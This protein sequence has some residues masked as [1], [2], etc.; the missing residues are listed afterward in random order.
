[1]KIK[2]KMDQNKI[3]KNLDFLIK[4]IEKQNTNMHLDKKFQ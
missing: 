4:Q 2:K 3:I 1:M